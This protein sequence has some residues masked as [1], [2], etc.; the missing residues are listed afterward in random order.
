M[1]DAAEH[2][3]ALQ[4]SS[5]D[6]GIELFGVADIV[7][8]RAEFLLHEDLKNSLHRGLAIGKRVLDPV[9]ADIDDHP[10]ALY[11]HHYRQLNFFLDRGAF[12][13]AVFIRDRGFRA[14]PIAASQIIDWDSRRAHISQQN[15]GRLAGVGV[16]G[17]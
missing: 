12:L 9:L 16:S 3:A 6:I 8:I 11:L 10:T 13:L 5:R 7:P 1:P 14:L 15:G 4:E 17:P 2:K